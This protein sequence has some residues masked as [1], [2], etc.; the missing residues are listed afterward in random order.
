[1][2]DKLGN[3]YGE[4]AEVKPVVGDTIIIQGKVK[5]FI[6]PSGETLIE[7]EKA[8]FIEKTCSAKTYALTIIPEIY[9]LGAEL[10]ENAETTEEYYVKGKIISIANDKYGNVT[11]QDENGYTLYVYGINDENGV[12]YDGMTKKPQVG[13]TV[14][15]RAKIKRYV[16]NSGETIELYQSTY[17][18]YE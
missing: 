14:V 18:P 3:K 11:I 2:Y 6:Q 8:K 13:D 4:F 7:I 12:R 15:L 9:H 16:N 1:L 10:A 5:R 17:I